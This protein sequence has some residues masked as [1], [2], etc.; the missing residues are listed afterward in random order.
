MIKRAGWGGVGGGRSAGRR[1]MFGRSADREDGSPPLRIALDLRHGRGRDYLDSARSKSVGQLAQANQERWPGKRS[2]TLL[3]QYEKATTDAAC[4]RALDGPEGIV[5]SKLP[6]IRSSTAPSTA[7]TPRNDSFGWPT[8]S[9]PYKLIPPVKPT[10]EV[11]VLR[12]RP[13]KVEERT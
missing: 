3:R 13:K 2:D 8:K 12:L 9:N 4:G 1:L 11:V 5:A 6:V 10:A 7:S